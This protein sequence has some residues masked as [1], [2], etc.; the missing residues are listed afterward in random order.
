MIRDTF[1]MI[2]TRPDGSFD[3]DRYQAIAQSE[4]RAEMTRLFQT[5][6]SLMRRVFRLR[7]VLHAE[8]A[9]H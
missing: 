9:R 2:L 5:L 4:R 7:P 6:R 1:P 8:R 3:T